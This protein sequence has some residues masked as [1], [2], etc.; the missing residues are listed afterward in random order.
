KGSDPK[1]EEFHIVVSKNLFLGGPSDIRSMIKEAS[2]EAEKFVCVFSVFSG[3][4]L[5]GFEFFGYITDNNFRDAKEIFSE[6][7]GLYFGGTAFMTVTTVPSA[8]W[9]G[10]VKEKIASDYDLSRLLMFHNS[11]VLADPIARFLSLYT[12]MLHENNDSQLEVDK[13]ILEIDPNVAQWKRP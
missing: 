4:K 2:D 1:R 10:E 8:P 7:S 6:T 3:I 11:A 9:V 13:A 12:V 5:F